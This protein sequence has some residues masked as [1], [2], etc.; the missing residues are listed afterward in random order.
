M[1][2][3][4]ALMYMGFKQSHYDYLLCTKLIDSDI[5]VVLV[6]ID[7]LLV[8]GS[9]YQILCEARQEIQKK[10]KIKDLDELKFFLGIEFPRSAKGIVMS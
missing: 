7:N 10:F 8:T 6:Y 1:K 9:N 3:T 4:E 2:L 5:V